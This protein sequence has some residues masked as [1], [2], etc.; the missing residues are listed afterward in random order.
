VGA[1]SLPTDPSAGWILAGVPHRNWV[2]PL[3]LHAFVAPSGRRVVTVADARA[4]TG[5]RVRRLGASLVG[6][7]IAVGPGAEQGSAADRIDAATSLIA[8]GSV[9]ALFPEVG[10]PAPPPTLRRLS[11]GVGH[12][13]AISAADIVPVAFGGTDELYLG[14]RIEIRV[15][16]AVAPPVDASRIA[17]SDWMVEFG[18]HVQAAA[19]NV[20]ELANSRQ[21]RRKRWTWLTG[22][23]PRA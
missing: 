13:S 21:P 4:V 5:S 11:V 2:E 14:R 23:Y 19:I 18:S 6:G 17:I 20:H 22:N 8:H 7:V 1:E 15:L 12:I 3:L 9:L 10:R 16:P